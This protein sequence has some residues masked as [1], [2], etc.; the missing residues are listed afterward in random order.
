MSVIRDSLFVFLACLTVVAATP[1]LFLWA[2]RDLHIEAPTLGKTLR[3]DQLRHQIASKVFGA[4]PGVYK[5][6]LT[7]LEAPSLQLLQA[8]S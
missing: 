7:R 5:N 2:S 4:L 8:A 1:P 3:N 6:G